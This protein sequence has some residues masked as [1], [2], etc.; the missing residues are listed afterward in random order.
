MYKENFLKR[1]AENFYNL[2]WIYYNRQTDFNPEE[3]KVYENY[4]FELEKI[5]S[6][7]PI[8]LKNIYFNVKGLIDK[9]EQES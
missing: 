4:L 6:E 7:L 2:Q 1:L 9:S 3:F 8:W 5:Y